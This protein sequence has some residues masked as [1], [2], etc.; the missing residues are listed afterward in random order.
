MER[1]RL[2]M[3]NQGRL[4]ADKTDRKDKIQFCPISSGPNRV[5]EPDT[6]P[7]PERTEIIPPYRGE[8]CPGVLSGPDKG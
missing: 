4:T 8:F 2:V 5:P 7:P 6:T 3:E 1:R